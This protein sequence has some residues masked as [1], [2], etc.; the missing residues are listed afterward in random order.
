V[1]SGLVILIVVTVMVVVSVYSAST[2]GRTTIV[3]G[4]DCTPQAGGKT[5]CCAVV[6]HEFVF[7]DGSYGDEVE[8]YCTTCDNTSPPSNCTPRERV[9]IVVDPGRELSNIL[10]GGIQGG[11]V[12]EDQTTT[13]PLEGQRANVTI[14]PGGII[15]E[16]NTSD[17]SE[18]SDLASDETGNATRTA[19]DEEQDD[20]ETEELEET[21]PSMKQGAEEADN[22][23]ENIDEE[24]PLE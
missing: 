13:T 12:L 1:K 17:N 19:N 5:R 8:Y 4:V 7:P 3:G 11:S 22:D 21:G 6:H 2:F 14:F 24:L 23:K 16:T 18:Q 15:Q 20:G 10:Q 9:S